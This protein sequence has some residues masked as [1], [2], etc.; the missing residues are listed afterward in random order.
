[1]EESERTLAALTAAPDALEVLA[2]MNKKRELR[3]VDHG[4]VEYLIVRKNLYTVPRSL[5][6]LSPEEVAARRARIG[7]KVRGRGAPAPV[8]GFGEAGL[9]EKLVGLLDKRGIT[10]PFPVQA[11]CI[12]AI[13]AGRD[14]VS[15]TR[16]VVCGLMLPWERRSAVLIPTWCLMPTLRVVLTPPRPLSSSLS[17]SF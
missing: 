14:V 8:S 9:S 6:G 12:P 1:M 16:A 4:S 5:A 10:E 7:V 3:S 2:E 15:Y 17:P 11:Q 13:M